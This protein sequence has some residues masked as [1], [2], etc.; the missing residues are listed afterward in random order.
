LQRI[1][2]DGGQLRVHRHTI[3]PFIPLRDMEEKWLPVVEEEEEASNKSTESRRQD[4]Q[5]LVQEVRAELVSW[6]ARS[7]AIEFVREGLGLNEQGDGDGEEGDSESLF[8]NESSIK[9]VAATSL[10]VRYVRIQWAGGAVGRLKLSNEGLVER[11]VVLGEEGREK[12]LE[13][14][15][16]EGPARVEDLA[17]RLAS[18]PTS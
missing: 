18:Y 3:P 5:R 10:E 7:D 17:Q 11:A 16:V 9:S 14:M 6:H 4:L 1:E 15:L 2:R 12:R 8:V 13:N